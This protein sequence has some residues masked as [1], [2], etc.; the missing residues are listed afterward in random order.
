SSEILVEA[1]RHHA[2]VKEV[3]ITVRARASGVSKK[4]SSLKYGFRFTK[5][6]IQTWLRQVASGLRPAERRGQ[7]HGVQPELPLA[8]RLRGDRR[9]GVPAR[10]GTQ[11]VPGPPAA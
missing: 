4:P 8:D 10:R 9:V 11:L 3:P 7:L 5:V 1:L 2:R 6:I